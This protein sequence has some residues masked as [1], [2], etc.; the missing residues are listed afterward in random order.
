MSQNNI[1]VCLVGAGYISDIHAEVLTKTPN[2]FV[3]AVVDP[4][5]AAAEA[6]G[7]KWGAKYI[8]STVEEAIASGQVSRAHILVP[9]HLHKGVA[10]QFIAAKIPTLIEKPV[11]VSAEEC[12]SLRAVIEASG[13]PAGVNQN[14]VYHPA[15]IR[16]QN[17]L[18][19]N[20]FGRL[21]YVHC[22]YSAPLRQLAA[23]QFSHWMFQ[24][25]GNILLEQAVHPLSQITAIAGDI[26]SFS[27]SAGK[28]VEIA[29]GT[30]F[31]DSAH[32]DLQCAR[33]PAQLS[34]AVGKNFPFWQVTAVCDDGVI[35]ADFSHNQCYVHGRTRWLDAADHAV[36]GLKTAWGIAVQSVRGIAEYA[37][38]TAALKP[39]SDPFYQSMQASIRAFHE[40]VDAGKPVRCDVDFGARLVQVCEEIAAK[41]FSK[42]SIHA[43]ATSETATAC[44]VAVLGGTGFI[45]RH[46]VGQLV[47]AQKRVA[48][49]ARSTASL[50]EIYHH[51]LVT[52]IRGDVRNADDVARGI[53][54]APVVVNLAHGG[55][56]A[57]WLAVEAAMVGSARTVADACLA[58][59]VKR[60]V[61]IGSIAG[62]YLGESGEIITG[63]TPPDSQAEN[64]ADYSRA[65]AEADR[66][67]LQMHRD[68]QLPVVILRPGVVV[69]E[70][71]SPFHSGLGLFNN[72]QHCL[73]WNK[74]DN[75]LPFV[76]A[77][78]VAAAIAAACTSPEIEGKSYNLVGGAQM[79]A[80]DYI[81]ALGA[82]T[83][84][85]LYFHGQ[86]PVKL[87][88]VE[89]CKWLIKRAA[90]RNV[91]FPNYRDLL[92]RGMTA[93]FDCSDA[94]RDLNWQPV[95]DKEQFI[96]RAISIF[97]P[98]TM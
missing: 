63:P 31:Y 35:V 57:D 83:R 28:P 14:F 87:Q 22:L 93:R 5:R 97:A 90:G 46:V 94:R 81:A 84:R 11:C 32:V 96:T 2:V 42:A 40:A 68:K 77:D 6:L 30:P 79:S 56:G 60:L 44:D 54:D 58:A 49:M 8:F 24:Q 18:A 37:L 74:G 9:P 20:K 47:S 36:S 91:G 59:G 69:G 71:S 48:V 12:V 64:R 53:G 27:A 16:M 88:A 70:G 85:P 66:M 10:A 78:D 34:F 38:A 86:S 13:T 19:Q 43:I 23:G 95:D 73:G 55:G 52:V 51:P 29:P 82:A 76:L 7:K 50:P 72:D 67:L 21:Q 61:H 65:K 41:I 75:P 17:L 39:R 33:A 1:S 45:G 80:R 89:I 25:P 92:S 98:A 3:G 62:L 15:L 26:L 4:N